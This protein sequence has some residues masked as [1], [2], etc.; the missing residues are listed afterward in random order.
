MNTESSPESSVSPVVAV[1]PGNTGLNRPQS[2]P[3]A[4]IQDVNRISLAGEGANII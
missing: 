4:D 3:I 1:S 2:S